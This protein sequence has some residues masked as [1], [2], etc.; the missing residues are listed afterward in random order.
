MT[1]YVAQP[2]V[3]NTSIIEKLISSIC[4][5]VLQFV[6]ATHINEFE[7]NKWVISSGFSEIKRKTNAQG[8]YKYKKQEGVCYA[9]SVAEFAK[10]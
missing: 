7:E 6:A 3:L 4:F 5:S 2:N 1:V 9:V 10:T 8:D